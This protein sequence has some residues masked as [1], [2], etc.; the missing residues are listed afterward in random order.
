LILSG[1][2]LMFSVWRVPPD[3]VGVSVTDAF[4]AALPAVFFLVFGI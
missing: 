2:L 1:A 4:I 3:A